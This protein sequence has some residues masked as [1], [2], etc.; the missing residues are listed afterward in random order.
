MSFGFGNR[1]CVGDSNAGIRLSGA[2]DREV[3]RRRGHGAA[4]QTTALRR[5]NKETSRELGVT[6]GRCSIN[7]CLRFGI[8]LGWRPFWPVC[9][10]RGRT[11]KEGKAD[12]AGKN[13]QVE[14]GFAQ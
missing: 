4:V 14:S 5:Q 3:N 9:G 1:N 7:A 6:T 8:C 11:G 10:L 12:G 13:A 2:E